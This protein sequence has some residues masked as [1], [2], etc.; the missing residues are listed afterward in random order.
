M[1]CY[2]HLVCFFHR[3]HTG[4]SWSCL[5]GTL[6]LPAQQ[7]R[8]GEDLLQS[9]VVADA[10]SE[11][12]LSWVTGKMSSYACR[13]GKH[14]F[15]SDLHH[16]PAKEEEDSNRA[17]TFTVSKVYFKCKN[18]TEHRQISIILLVWS[19]LWFCQKNKKI[20]F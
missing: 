16:T 8:V 6:A 10:K 5:T 19:L 2:L 17:D 4:L 1:L 13:E 11:D 15:S 9:V 18:C 7:L 20:Y 14:N 12:G 3:Q